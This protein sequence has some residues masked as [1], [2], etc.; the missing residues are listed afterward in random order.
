MTRDDYRAVDEAA[1]AYATASLVIG[2][3]F[4]A[5]EVA[6]CHLVIADVEDVKAFSAAVFAH[7]RAL[8][9]YIAAVSAFGIIGRAYNV[10]LD[11]RSSAAV[12]TPPLETP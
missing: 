9:A 8:N 4:D 2:F 5:I 6:H 12:P 11:G 7:T 1:S 10:I 3:T